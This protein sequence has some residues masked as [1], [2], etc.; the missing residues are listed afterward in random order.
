[1]PTSVPDAPHHDNAA[2]L[3]GTRGR[4]I[5]LLHCTNALQIHRFASRKCES[6]LPQSLLAGSMLIPTFPAA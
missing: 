6:S 5:R 2:L 1:M 3:V 4:K